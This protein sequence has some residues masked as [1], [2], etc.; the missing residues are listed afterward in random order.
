MINNP[1]WNSTRR[2]IE[3]TLGYPP[4]SFD[5]NKS[6][7]SNLQQSKQKEDETT[8]LT[9]EEC[10]RLKEYTD[11]WATAGQVSVLTAEE[12][13]DFITMLNKICNDM[14]TDKD[15]TNQRILQ[16]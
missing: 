5:P 3:E 11:R 15:A 8:S 16:G 1:A 2:E 7:S 4:G 6:F 14:E 12:R 13:Q 10:K 9:I